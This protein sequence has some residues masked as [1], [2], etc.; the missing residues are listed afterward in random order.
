MAYGI[1]R[2]PGAWRNISCCWSSCRSGPRSCCASMPGS[3]CSS[4]NG[5][6][7]SSCSST[8]GMHRTAARSDAEHR[9]RRLSRHRLFLPALHDPAALRHPGKARRHADRGGA[10]IS[11]RAPIAGLLA[12]DAARCRMPGIIAGC[13]LVFIPAIG[14]FVI[15][16]CS[17]APPTLM[18]G[19]VICGRVLLQPRLAD[20]LGRRRRPAAAAR[21]ADHALPALAGAKPTRAVDDEAPARRFP[22]SRVCARLCLPLRADPLADRLLLQR[23]AARHRLGRLLDQMVRSL[24]NNQQ[25][26][27]AAWLSLESRA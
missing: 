1:A 21:R 22:S 4:Q 16:T 26:I 7:T 24:F 19:R 2:A 18:I 11:A 25:V 12:S 27:D 13:L 17:A 8:L 23:V 20:G 5:C 14:E 9:F 10:W 15:P 3:A 6:S